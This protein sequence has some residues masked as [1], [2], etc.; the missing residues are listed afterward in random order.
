[1]FHK[2]INTTVLK[3]SDNASPHIYHLLANI[4]NTFVVYPLAYILLHIVIEESQEHTLRLLKRQ[5]HQLMSIL[6]VHYL[7]TD[8]V[9]SLNEIYQRMTNVAQRLSGFRLTCYAHFVGY[10]LV[11]LLL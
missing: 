11:Y 5:Y 1:M 7:I 10:S 3:F 2:G 8:I 9:G 4:G 6:N